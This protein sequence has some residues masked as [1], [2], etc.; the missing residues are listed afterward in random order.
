MTGRAGRLADVELSPTSLVGSFCH[1]FGDWAGWQGCVVAEPSPGAYLVEFFSWMGGESTHQQ[2]VRL[3]EMAGWR[4]YDSADWMNFA[5]EHGGVSA[6][7]DR[8]GDPS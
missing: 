5:Y 6:K 8:A 7:W 2:L 4:F 1:G 3:D